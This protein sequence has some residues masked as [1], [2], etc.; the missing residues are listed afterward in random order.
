MSNNVTKEFLNNMIYG[1]GADTSAFRKVPYVT[2]LAKAGLR[3]GTLVGRDSVE[4]HG[5]N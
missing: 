2:S 4:E 1:T 5:P 3:A